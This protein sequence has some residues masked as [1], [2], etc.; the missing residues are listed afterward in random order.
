MATPEGIRQVHEMLAATL[1][2]I[3]EQRKPAEEFLR[4]NEAVRAWPEPRIAPAV[5]RS[6]PADGLVYYSRVRLLISPGWC[7]QAP[8]FSISMLEAAV[9]P[10]VAPQNRLLAMLYFKNNVVRCEET[11]DPRPPP[12][13]FCVLVAAP[14]LCCRGLTS[15]VL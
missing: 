3:D 12:Q 6:G 7:A 14:H 9:S 4:K 15:R 10:E 11:S 8:G 1:S 13:P 5:P 2:P